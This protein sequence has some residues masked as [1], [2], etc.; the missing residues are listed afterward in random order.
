MEGTSRG[1]P[2]SNK[3]HVLLMSVVTELGNKVEEKSS[4]VVVQVPEISYIFTNAPYGHGQWI[5]Q[6][7]DQVS[8]SG[9][10]CTLWA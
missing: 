3:P 1:E 5:G 10:S 7:I 4:S 8:R 6:A 9:L 2:W